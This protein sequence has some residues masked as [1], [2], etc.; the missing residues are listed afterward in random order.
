[1]CAH[2][3]SLRIYAAT[4]RLA[5]MPSKHSERSALVPAGRYAEAA[6][7]YSNF[8][9]GT[10]TQVLS[11]PAIALAN[12]C[13][14][15][16]LCGANDTAEAMMQRVE[17]EEV[18]C[19]AEVST[20]RYLAV[21]CMACCLLLIVM[22]QETPASWQGQDNTFSYLTG[23]RETDPPFVCHQPGH[24]YAVLHQRYIL[25]PGLRCTL[26]AELDSISLVEGPEH[27]KSKWPSMQA[28]HSTCA[29][30]CRKIA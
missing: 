27:V 17:D 16:I 4:E 25:V 11:V 20:C 2:N 24:W 3:F 18:H 29:L 22:L 12:L 7:H 23:T 30:L 10:D 6:A 1:M 26:Q 5:M 28:L 14:A 9:A 21:H 8:V 13:A 15:H 19:H